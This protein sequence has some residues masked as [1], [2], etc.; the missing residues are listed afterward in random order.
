MIQQKVDVVGLLDCVRAVGVDPAPYIL[1]YK[2]N[3]EKLKGVLIEHDV[4][5]EEVFDV[6]ASYVYRTPKSG[7]KLE[8]HQ[9]VQDKIEHLVSAMKLDAGSSP[10]AV[11]SSS[12]SIN[13]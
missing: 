13:P 6:R 2:V 12:L 7:D 9:S 8:F 3:E 5:P 10:S 11:S 1:S 4:P